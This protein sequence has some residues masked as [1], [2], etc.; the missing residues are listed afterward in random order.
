M[1]HEEGSRRGFTKRMDGGWEH[2]VMVRCVRLGGAGMI[3]LACRS[4]L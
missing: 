1:V 4:L 2:I 3:V